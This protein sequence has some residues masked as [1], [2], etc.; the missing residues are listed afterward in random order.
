MNRKEFEAFK[1]KVVRAY[2]TEID[3]TYLMDQASMETTDEQWEELSAYMKSDEVKARLDEYNSKLNE[4]PLT[5][6]APASV[7]A[8]TLQD[9]QTDMH[10]RAG[11]SHLEYKLVGADLR[12][13]VHLANYNP[14]YRKIVEQ[15]AKE[16]GWKVVN[17]WKI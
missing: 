6:C 10:R 3:Y 16:K 9:F 11:L 14:R 5:I 7:S 1:K 12:L 4:K 15:M 17:E 8:I 13:E 2:I